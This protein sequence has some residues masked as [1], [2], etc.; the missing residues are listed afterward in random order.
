MEKGVY[1]DELKQSVIYN[2]HQHLI[3][4]KQSNNGIRSCPTC[5]AGIAT[6]SVYAECSFC[7]DELSSDGSSYYMDYIDRMNDR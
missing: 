7:G 1:S 5:G 4:S 3:F 6:T 2:K